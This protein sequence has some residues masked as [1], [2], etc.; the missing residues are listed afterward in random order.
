MCACLCVHASACVCALRVRAYICV[1]VCACVC[2]LR[3]RL[4]VRACVCALRV[5][6]CVCVCVSVR[7]CAHCVYMRVCACMHVRG[8]CISRVFAWCLS[9]W[10]P[11]PTEQKQNSCPANVSFLPNVQP[12]EAE[13]TASDNLGLPGPGLRV[14]HAVCPA[15]GRPQRPRRP[16][17]SLPG[18]APE[19]PGFLSALSSDLLPFSPSP[20]SLWE[21][22]ILG[23][24]LCFCKN[25]FNFWTFYL[26]LSTKPLLVSSRR[27]FR[28]VGSS[29]PDTGATRRGQDPRVNKVQ[30]VSALAPRGQS[31]GRDGEQVASLA[32]GS[33]GYVLGTPEGQAHLK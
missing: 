25:C 8:M 23:H 18:W 4:R 28:A 9:R 30:R 26:T 33:G 6:A 13:L 21:P 3:V 11:Q 7:A 19:G 24:V 12:K 22:V 32:E 10:K 16:G 14:T 5:R 17:A 1:S 20:A 29:L 15:K 31:L 2:A 27:T